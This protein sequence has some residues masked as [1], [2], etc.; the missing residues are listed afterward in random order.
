MLSADPLFVFA[1]L[2][3]LQ[4]GQLLLVTGI[5]F[6]IITLIYS[7]VRFHQLIQLSEEELQTV[8]DCNDFFF[9]QVTR[10]LSK[11]NRASA[12]F[13]III[14]QIRS[15]TSNL[16]PMQEQLLHQLHNLTRNKVD[17]TCLFQKDCVAALIDTDE[18]NVQA[19]AERIT[20][21][22]KTAAASIPQITAIR[23]GS[24]EFPAHGLKTRQLIDAATGALE[25]ADFDTALPLSIAPVPESDEEKTETE[26]IGELSKTDKNSSLDPLT[27]VLK[28]DVI[29]SYMRKYLSE[30]RQKKEPAAVLCVGI[31][32]IDNIIALH[33]EEAADA[34]IAGVSAV[35][36]R[37]TRDSDLIGRFHRDDFLILAPCTLE[38]GEMIA[39][40][41][42]DAVQKEVITCE[43][44]RLKTSISVGV[45]GHPEHGRALRDLFKAS[46]TALEVIRS[47]GTTACLVYDPAH[48]SQKNHHEKAA[49]TRR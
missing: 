14:A 39:N 37:F 38:Q 34:A 24:C 22:L 45:S 13:G 8:E 21:E 26:E 2:P 9:I 6:A 25:A 3:L 49:E 15:D 5:A 41:L 32:R 19:V 31:N 11:I 46:H 33:G 47:W 7:T 1:Q 42:R 12:G 27:G 23:T 43:G 28:P 18:E 10:Y 48:H 4:A 17:K 35:L 40:R 16:R 36:Q 44:K 29:G 20:K 30:L